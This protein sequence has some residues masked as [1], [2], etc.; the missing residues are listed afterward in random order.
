MTLEVATDN[1]ALEFQQNGA[2][3]GVIAAG[4]KIDNDTLLFIG[5]HWALMAATDQLFTIPF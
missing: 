2:T 3:K 4:G 1:R 5:D